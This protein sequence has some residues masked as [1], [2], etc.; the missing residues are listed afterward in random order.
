MSNKKVRCYVNMTGKAKR[1][2]HEKL[3]ACN[4]SVTQ[5]KK[6]KWN[7]QKVVDNMD[8]SRDSCCLPLSLSPS[9]PPECPPPPAFAS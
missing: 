7:F 1:A 2:W 9:L 3:Q 4:I 5:S 8:H 6:Y